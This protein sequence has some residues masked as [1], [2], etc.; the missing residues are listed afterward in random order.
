[1]TVNDL[2]DQA[3]ATAAAGDHLTALQLTD[4]ALRLDRTRW[5]SLT[6]KGILCSELGESAAAE[7]LL[8]EAI[9]LAPSEAT[10]RYDLA[11][12]FYRQGHRDLARRLAMEALKVAPEHEPTRWLIDTIEQGVPMPPAAPPVILAPPP[13]IYPPQ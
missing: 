13:L 11:I 8:R 10:P 1:M 12:H 3:I 7:H 9:R 4:A 5:E 6:L 2:L